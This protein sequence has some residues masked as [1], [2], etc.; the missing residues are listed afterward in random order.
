MSRV[1]KR[2]EAGWAARPYAGLG[3]WIALWL[4]LFG[5]ALF[6]EFMAATIDM[7]LA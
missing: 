5:G 1:L 4:M 6:F 2:P 7:L 3:E